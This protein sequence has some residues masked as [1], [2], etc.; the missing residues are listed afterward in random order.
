M[1]VRTFVWQDFFKPKQILLVGDKRWGMAETVLLYEG[2]E[3]W[4]VGRWKEISASLLPG[5][6]DQQIRLRTA[7]VSSHCG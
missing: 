2:L 1:E 6:S 5:W 3:R 4:G 7:R